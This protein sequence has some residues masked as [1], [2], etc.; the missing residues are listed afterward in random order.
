LIAWFKI[1]LTQATSSRDLVLLQAYLLEDLHIVY[2]KTAGQVQAVASAV[3]AAD[4]IAAADG[5]GA[6]AAGCTMLH[7][8]M[9]I[10]C[11]R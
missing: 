6:H 3:A 8:S 9:L 5:T 10:I 1:C 11:N 7:A 2:G 4:D